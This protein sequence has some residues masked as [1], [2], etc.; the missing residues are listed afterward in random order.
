[1]GEKS[2]SYNRCTQMMHQLPL[3]IQR[4]EEATFANFYWEN[5]ALIEQQLKLAVAG[6]GERLIYLWG[7]QSSGKSHLLQACCYALAT[8]LVSYLPLTLLKACGPESL[9]GLE[10]HAFIGLDDIDAIAGDR[11]FEIALFHLYNRIRDQGHGLLMLSGTC[12]PAQ[13]P[14]QLPDL[15]SRLCWGLTLHINPLSDEGKVK[16]LQLHAQKC[17]FELPDKVGHFLL[18]RYT[19]SLPDLLALLH[20]LDEASLIAQ[21]KMT[22]PFVKSICKDI[23]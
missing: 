16:T 13:L 8:Q 10:G 17:G 14:L 3:T 23:L 11:H 21:R 2:L 6:T 12:P 19:R 4:N 22:I 20:Q 15:K 5:N 18:Q 1:M 7:S 9:E